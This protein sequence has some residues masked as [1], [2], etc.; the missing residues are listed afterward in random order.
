M[1]K[2][3]KWFPQLH[4]HDDHSVKDGCSSV[5]TYANITRDLKGTSLCITNHGRAAGYAR[6]F[7]ACKERGLKP[8]FG[9]EAYINE[10]RHTNIREKLDE[11]RKAQRKTKTKEGGALVEKLET[12]LKTEFRPSRH[13][14][15]IAKNRE[16]YRNLVKMSSDSWQTGFYYAPRTD[17]KFLEAHA[18]GLIYSTA[19]YGGYIPTL[20][21]ND[22]DK[23]E[24]EARRLQGI[25][26][27]D[28]FYVE[29]MMTAYEK[30]REVNK[31]MLQLASDLDAPVIVTCDIHY[32]KPEDQLAQRCLLLMRDKLTIKAQEAGEGGW[33]FD[34]KDLYWKTLED[35]MAVYKAHHADY[36]PAEDFKKA[37][38]NTYALADSIEQVDFD[39]SLKF[40]GVFKDAEATMKELASAGFK[41]KCSDGTIPAS[42]RTKMEYFERLKREVSVI[43]PKGFAE[44][45]LILHD[46]CKHARSVGARMGPGRGSAGGSL[47]AYLLGIT[48]IDPLRFN[49]LFERF[50]DENRK[51]APDIDLDFSPEHRPLIREYI[52]KRYP[53]TATIGTF[54]TFKPRSTI[55][56]VGRV[57]D[58]DY[59]ET[60]KLTKPMGGEKYEKE[61][62]SEVGVDRMTWEQMF[63]L[64]PEVKGW[65]NQYPEAWGVVKTLRGLI[66]HR[67][68][69][70]A[71]ILIAPKWA[72]E[73]LPLEKDTTDGTVTTAWTDTSVEG[74]GLDYQGR[75]LSRLGYLKMDILGIQTLNVA[76]RAAEILKRDTGI[77]IDVEKIPLDD[78]QTLALA[79][80]GDVTGAFQ[81]D[82]PTSVPILRKV[83]VDTFMDLAAVTAL[84]R[85]GPL[86]N[87]L[88]EK[89]GELKQ[90]G[91][92]WKTL[93]PESVHD[94]L[95]ESRGLMI[96]QEDVMFVLQRLG[97]FTMQESNGVRKIIAKKLDAKTL[98]EWRGKFVDGG[99]KLGHD[100]G[101]LSKLFD[102][103]GAYSKYAFNKSH[104]VAY[105]LTGYRQIYM[106]AHHPMHYFA[107]LLTETPRGKKQAHRDDDRLMLFMRRAMNQGIKIF[108][109][110]VYT[111]TPDFDLVKDADGDLIGIQYGLGHIKGVAGAAQAVI[112]ATAKHEAQAPGV[113]M[114]IEDFLD[115]VERRRCH[116]GIV[117]AL[118][119]AGAFDE[120][121][122]ADE[123][124][125]PVGIQSPRNRMLIRAAWYGKKPKKGE[126]SLPLPKLYKPSELLA[127]ERELLGL[128]LSWWSGSDK[129]DLRANHRLDT[130]HEA[131]EKES[132]R[133]GVVAEVT[134][135]R[136]HRTKNKQTMAFLAVA[137]ETGTLDNVIAFGDEWKK[138]G[139]HLHPGDICVLRF[140][141]KPSR[142]EQY[143]KWSF[144]LDPDSQNPVLLVR[145]RKAVQA[146]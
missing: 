51:D 91:D 105:A 96:Y 76:P 125:I 41:R 114:T 28:S 34:T 93:V 5:E 78:E 23:G 132:V 48:D 68:K 71:G 100:P 8:I 141:R 143:G 56:D 92:H 94:V 58:V 53:A 82:T 144:V 29:V 120:V 121:G 97:G 129:D 22:K 99:T 107:A 19:C 44:Y 9:M 110:S 127:Q 59:Q 70:A 32:A 145:G 131:N 36:Y 104:S 69:H 27:K 11:A 66:S 72:L 103:L 126:T 47:V 63:E 108:P 98:D 64:W 119:L 10:K 95:A 139:P 79:N 81:F 17:T 85:P 60:A 38:K 46:I 116:I 25:F 43:N 42:G 54:S 40:P 49:L 140:R 4:T 115:N 106:L 84:V 118:I 102:T 20:Y 18:G 37:I 35:V 123:G 90:K 45:F 112:A 87:K 3:G 136:P 77:D 142:D 133:F 26:G 113:R 124:G 21:R 130:I 15:I 67:G 89:F 62:G 30:Q 61:D 55:Q 109:P 13:A 74:G 101:M 50:L 6:Q 75:E 134:R 138:Y 135:A 88:P 39:T 111:K 12:F 1:T 52:E 7:F 24:A 65:S 33:Q 16:G 86:Q 57:F 146:P 14:V 122:I 80:M 83:G 117:G 128:A 73:E 31:Q 137:D 2:S